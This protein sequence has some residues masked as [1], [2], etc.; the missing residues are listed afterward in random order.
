MTKW[1]GAAMQITHWTRER[2]RRWFSNCDARDHKGR[3]RTFVADYFEGYDLSTLDLLTKPFAETS[4]AVDMWSASGNGW[5]YICAVCLVEEL[6]DRLDT[7][8]GERG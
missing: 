6:G 2:T 8:E 3:R 5:I 4:R 7:A 1:E